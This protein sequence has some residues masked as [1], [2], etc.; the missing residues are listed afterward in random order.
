MWTD[1]YCYIHNCYKPN[2]LTPAYTMYSPAADFAF[3]NS[4][5]GKVWPNAAVTAGAFWNYRD[6]FVDS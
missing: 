4:V 1:A 5:S 3:T 2:E 6:G